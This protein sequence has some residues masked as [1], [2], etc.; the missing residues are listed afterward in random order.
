MSEVVLDASALQPTTL[1]A[2]RGKPVV[3]TPHLGELERMGMDPDTLSDIAVNA[4]IT[5]LLKGTVDLVAEPDGTLH[6]VEGG[7][8]G[9]TAGGT[10]DVL[11]GL[12]GGLI[13]QGVDPSEAALLGSRVMKQAATELYREYGYAYG[14]RRVIDV[15]PR[16]L[17]GIDS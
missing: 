3:L 8:A 2:V 16:I 7:N 17:H 10:G 14:P 15:I 4:G 11:A 12:I 5:I 6:E 1:D 13:A 9:L